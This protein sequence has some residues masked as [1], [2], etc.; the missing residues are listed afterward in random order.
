MVISD[1]L[2]IHIQ[3]VRII[4]PTWRQHDAEEPHPDH[5]LIDRQ[6]DD[7][8]FECGLHLEEEEKHG[9]GAVCVGCVRA[10]SVMNEYR[11]QR[12]RSTPHS[13][14]HQSR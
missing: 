1:A 9:G 13:P 3:E 8:V 4:L 12:Q 11:H 14:T 5:E 10:L 2:S 6:E 7:G